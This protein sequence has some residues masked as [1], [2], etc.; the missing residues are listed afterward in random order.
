M[1]FD[2]LALFIFGCQLCG[3][4]KWSYTATMQIGYSLQQKQGTDLCAIVLEVKSLLRL[5]TV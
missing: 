2:T 5:Q 1:R 3:F 4:W